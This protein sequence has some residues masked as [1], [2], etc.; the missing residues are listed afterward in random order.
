MASIGPSALGAKGCA[1]RLHRFARGGRRL[2]VRKMIECHISAQPRTPFCHYVAF[3]LKGKR[4]IWREKQG[5]IYFRYHFGVF[6]LWWLAPQPCTVGSMSYDTESK[7]VTLIYKHCP[8]GNPQP[9]ARRAV[10][11]TNPPAVRPVHL[12]NLFPQPFCTT[13]GGAAPLFLTC[14]E[15]RHPSPKGPYFFIDISH[16]SVLYCTL[17][18]GKMIAG[19]KA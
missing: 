2:A 6:S 18:A 19:R 13:R 10:I 5:V 15:S 11:L 4:E 8:K 9:S 17:R 12:K 16:F 3:P 7:S 14:G 1:E